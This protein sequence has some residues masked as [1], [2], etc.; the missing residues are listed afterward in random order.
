MFFGKGLTHHFDSGVWGN[1]RAGFCLFKAIILGKEKNC[2]LN[3]AFL[4]LKINLVLH[5]AYD[6]DNG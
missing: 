1:S 2:K 3:L 4:C 5:P 6:G